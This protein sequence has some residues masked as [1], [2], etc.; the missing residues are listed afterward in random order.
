MLAPNRLARKPMNRAKSAGLRGGAYRSVDPEAPDEIAL[1]ELSRDIRPQDYAA[2]YARL[3]LQFSERDLPLSVA[4][5]V[6]P[7]W[8]AAVVAEPGVATET[9]PQALAR[10]AAVPD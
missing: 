10:Y 6:R 4:A 3:A 8:L 1:V 2:T 7:P 5:V 9:L